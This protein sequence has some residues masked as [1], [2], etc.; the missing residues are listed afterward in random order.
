M[1]FTI[2]IIAL[3]A[4]G[5]L[6]GWYKGFLN[7]I[8]NIVSFFFAWLLAFLFCTPLSSSIISNKDIS[9]NLLYFTA[10]T[11]KL[12]D[13]TIANVDAASL[14]TEKIKQVIQQS[15]IPPHIANK[16]EYNILNQTFSD[17]D[18]YTM[19]EYFNQTLIDVSI[20]LICFLLIYFIIRIIC[21]FLIEL[22]DKT[23]RFPIL[24]KAD[25]PI[26]ALFGLIH[27]FMIISVIFS[28]IPIILTVIDIEFVQEQI[29]SSPIANFFYSNNII[30]GVL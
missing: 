7:T 24:K 21:S 28:I 19:G 18:I 27:G 5:C 29:N 14:S 11:E 16:L 23:F 6:I 3:F 15:N 30:S 25:S 20:N 9:T 2:L 8:C 17:Q 22:I 12:S 4:V 13:M 10:G 26:A 1:I